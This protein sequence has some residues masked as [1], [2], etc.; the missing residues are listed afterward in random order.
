MRLKKNT[1]ASV[2]VMGALGMVTVTSKS[3]CIAKDVR[4]ITAL[5]PQLKSIVTLENGR[6]QTQTTHR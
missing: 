6:L 2:A 1:S 5:K 4:F 3:I